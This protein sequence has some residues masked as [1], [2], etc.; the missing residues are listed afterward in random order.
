MDAIRSAYACAG[1]PSYVNFVPFAFIFEYIGHGMTREGHV[2][3]MGTH[4]YGGKL[5]EGA[6]AILT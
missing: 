4:G 3:Q 2:G 1:R 6:T 5:R